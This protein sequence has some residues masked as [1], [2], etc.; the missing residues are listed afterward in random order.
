MSLEDRLYPWLAA[1]NALPQWSQSVLGTVYRQLP[2]AWR[3]GFRYAEF[4]ELA[5]ASESWSVEEI[6]QYQLKQLRLVLHHA[7]NFCPYYQKVFARTAFRP[8]SVRT[9]DDMANCPLLEKRDLI[10][11]RDQLASTHV[12]ASQRLY[13]TTGGSTGIP[14]GFYLQKGVSRPKEQAFLEWMWARAG[15]FKHAKLAV[16]RGQM[17]SSHPNGRI[18]YYDAS[19]NWLML[20][21]SHLTPERIPD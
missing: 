13:I 4:A 5:R 2:Q 1:Y 20:S 6:Q 11:H 10:E 18:G 15:Y 14:V 3:L 19:R 8:E 17:T 16:I 12:P 9:L 7:A 21:S